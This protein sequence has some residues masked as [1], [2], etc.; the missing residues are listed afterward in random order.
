[1][2]CEVSSEIEN[3]NNKK[4][5]FRLVETLGWLANIYCM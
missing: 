1:M 3:N 5:A 2:S 4:G